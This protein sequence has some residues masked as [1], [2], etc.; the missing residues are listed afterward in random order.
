[1]ALYL[2]TG[3]AGFIG[4]NISGELVKRGEKVRI[5]DNFSTGKRE[6]IA[7]FKSGIELIEGDLREL[8]IVE[9]A[10]VGVDF[11]LHQGAL[12]SVERSI[13]DP[14]TTNRINI[15]GTLNVLLAALRLGV[16]RVVYASS[17]S[18]YGDTPTLPKK[19]GMKPTPQSP[20]AVTKL[21][22]EE[23][24]RI[25]YSIYGLE[26]VCLRYFNVFGPRQDPGSQYAAV[27]PK[28]ITLMLRGKSPPIYG[29]GEQSRDFT[30]ID[31]VVEANLQACTAKGAAGK[32]F[33][34]ACGKN[35]TINELVHRLNR[36]LQTKT[37]PAYQSPRK[38]DVK[39][40]LADISQARKILQYSPAIG[41][42]E[43]LV[44]TVQWFR[45][46]LS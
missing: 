33:N 3:G 37:E 30:F 10:M 19:E 29:D 42:D 38:G 11:V 16:E 4:S 9:R 41:F 25:Y 12:P 2:V 1:L 17:S 6:N 22:G 43:G 39:Y 8:E 18:V 23:Y 34:I 14:L 26:T 44:K 15:L 7:K 36:I 27:I 40:S 13:E 35:V 45:D 31:N 24:C 32:V 28:F 20:Y 46:T 21:V 5:L